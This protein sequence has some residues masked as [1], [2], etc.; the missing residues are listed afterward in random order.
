MILEAEFVEKTEAFQAEFGEVMVV[1]S[2]LDRNCVKTVNGIAPDK[3]GNVDVEVA[4]EQIASAVEN[5]LEENPIEGG[6]G[7]PGKDG[8]SATHS[9]NGTVLTV[10]SA[11][12]T[13]SADLKGEKGDPGR[14]AT[15]S[16]TPT[17][18]GWMVEITADGITKT[19]NLYHGQDGESVT[20]ESVSEST[21]DGG[22]NVVTFSD[23][24]TVTIK[25]G[26]KGS[27][28]DTGAAPV[29]GTDYW[30]E[31]DQAAIIQQV[32][33]T[34]GGTPVFGTVDANNNIILSGTLAEGT[35]TIKYEDADGN[36]TEIGTIDVGGMGNSGEIELV[37]SD[38][39]KLDKATGAEGSDAQYAASQ[40]ID[41]VDGYT[42]TAHQVN[43]EWGF[44][45][46]GI[47]I[48][49]YGDGGSYLG[50]EELW[51]SKNE[52]MSKQ[53]TPLAGAVSF[54]VRL[55]HGSAVFAEE[56]YS[57]TYEKTE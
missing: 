11:S 5:Y 48:C 24:K 17:V 25:N 9:W 35:Y 3:N 10:T 39:V 40:M 30:T 34:L 47:S 22:S 23:G 7:D 38:G 28:G 2:G 37:W 1:G 41:L 33:D 16:T 32:I 31:A 49:Y 57:I 6:K 45:T 4:D 54:R 26:S 27:K 55:F 46:G 44:T 13:S 15:C 14:P 8:I 12:G 21:A 51:A 53:F 42:Y 20:V 29:R 19:F 50:Y 43:D 18:D 56:R 52:E 36:V